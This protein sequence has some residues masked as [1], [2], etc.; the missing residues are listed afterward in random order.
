MANKPLRR[1]LS[2]Q[3]D[4]AVTAVLNTRGRAKGCRPLAWSAPA[5]QPWTEA[6]FSGLASSGDYSTADAGE[7]SRSPVEVWAV[8]NRDEHP[9]R[10]T[11]GYPANSGGKKRWSTC[12]PAPWSAPPGSPGPGLDPDA[13]DLS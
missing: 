8:A 5:H 4:D 11:L 12:R 7:P 13:L 9:I 10:G 1:A 2:E 6:G 3:L